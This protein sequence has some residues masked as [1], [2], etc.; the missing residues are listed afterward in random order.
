MKKIVLILIAVIS[1]NFA[2]GQEINNDK[3]LWAK[4]VLNEKA[5]KIEVEKWLSIK[6]D[7]T[8]GKFT[9]IDF[10]ATWCG[11]CRVYIPMLNDFHKKF[12]DR[13]NVIGISDEPEEKV[14]SFNNPKINY[15]EAVDPKKRMHKQLEVKA[16]PH[17]IIVSPKG[18]VIWEGFP[19]L[20]N[21]QLTE[22]VLTDLMEKY[23][24]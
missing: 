13:L 6:P 22:K 1:T 11:P 20:A 5:P 23:K 15:F 19:L 2:F 7:T 24:N 14:K 10:W 12:S 21:F 8:K 4:S 3:K 18:I 16:I 17:V 9:L